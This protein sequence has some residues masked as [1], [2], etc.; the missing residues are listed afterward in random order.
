MHYHYVKSCPVWLLEHR[1]LETESVAFLRQ[2]PQPRSSEQ[3]HFGTATQRAQNRH[4]APE[5]DTRPAELRLEAPRA[6]MGSRLGGTGHVVPG[7]IAGKV[8][9]YFGW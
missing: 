2:P 5:A 7:H 8:I 1:V 4:T 6:E 3:T 9:N